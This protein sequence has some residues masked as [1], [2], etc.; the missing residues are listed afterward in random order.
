MVSPHCL[1]PQ[2]APLETYRIILGRKNNINYRQERKGRN[3]S[4]NR[5]LN[6]G[7]QRDA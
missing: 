2:H 4:I 6:N 1:S 7:I 3:I 5:G